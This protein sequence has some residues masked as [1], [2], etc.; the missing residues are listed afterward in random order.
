M[1]PKRFDTYGYDISHQAIE[2]AEKT[3]AVKKL[4]TLANLMFTF[5]VYLLISRMICFPANRRAA[6]NCWKD[7]TR[8]KRRSTCINRKYHSQGDIEKVF[9][10]LSHRLHVVHAP[11]RWYAL[12]EKE[13]GVNQ[14]RVIGGVCN[15]CLKTGMQFYD[16]RIMILLY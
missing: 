15:C 4:L 9:E 7:F 12:E 11:H 16:V 2:R 8:G 5:Y 13:R 3:A 1:L 14:L 6:V 10:M